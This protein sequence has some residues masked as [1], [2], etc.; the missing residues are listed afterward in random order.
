M[1]FKGTIMLA[2]FENGS[3]QYKVSVGDLIKIDH[4]NSPEGTKVSFDKILI[5]FDDKNTE[6]NS[7]K[8]SKMKVTGTIKRHGRHKK[9]SVIKFK[10]RKHYMKTHGHKQTFTEIKIESIK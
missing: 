5:A 4:V 2:V 9:I 10:R 7:T 8:L 6:L 1:I 3:K